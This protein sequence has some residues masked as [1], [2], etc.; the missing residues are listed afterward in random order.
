[1]QP[2]SGPQQY[3]VHGKASLRQ[4][5][6]TELLIPPSLDQDRFRHPIYWWKSP[7]YFRRAGDTETNQGLA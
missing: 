1:M 2:C 4:E 6:E 7:Q 3:Q 5:E